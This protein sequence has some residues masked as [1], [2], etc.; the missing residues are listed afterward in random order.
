MV[1]RKRSLELAVTNLRKRIKM[2]ACFKAWASYTRLVWT[3]KFDK[4]QDY[5]ELYLQRICIR[6]WKENLLMARGQMLVAVDWH[7]MKLN[8]KYFSVW[9]AYTR[10]AK[11]IEETKLKHSENHYK[12]HVMWKMVKIRI[13]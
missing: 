12:F 6:V 13:L 5:Y 1:R 3:L 11:I 10:E 8:E 2:K 9:L 4:A 7:E